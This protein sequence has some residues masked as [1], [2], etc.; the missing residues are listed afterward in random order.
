VSG[1][2][3][4]SSCCCC[5]IKSLQLAQQ[6]HTA[7]AASVCVCSGCSTSACVPWDWHPAQVHTSRF[8]AGILTPPPAAAAPPP[9]RVRPS[10]L[11]HTFSFPSGHTTAAV[12]T[13]GALLLVLLPLL[14]E[15]E[16][17]QPGREG[18]SASGSTWLQTAQQQALELVQQASWAT[19]WRVV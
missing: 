6:V 11:H 7:W 19:C 3:S 16:Q 8:L 12:F 15:Q 9:L 10:T 17:E 1:S 18:S 13:V 2:S 4:S 5:S 14:L